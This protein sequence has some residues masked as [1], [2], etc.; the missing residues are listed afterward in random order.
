[1]FH[2]FILTSC[3][4]STSHAAKLGYPAA[5]LP[6]WEWESR[7]PCEKN[8]NLSDRG[9]C[10]SKERT[11]FQR[12]CRGINVKIMCRLCKLKNTHSWKTHSP[13]NWKISAIVGYLPRIQILMN[14]LLWA[15][16]KILVN[17]AAIHPLGSGWNESLEAAEEPK[18]CQPSQIQAWDSAE[19]SL[20]H[21]K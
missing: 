4:S 20:P 1:M 7:D 11:C 3:G 15:H 17:S 13:I 5:K 18:A 19:L 9:M 21:R 12:G 14:K 10:P 16:L 2:P 6:T 8:M